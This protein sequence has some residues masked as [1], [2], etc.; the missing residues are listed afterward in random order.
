MS[1]MQ[2]EVKVIYFIFQDNFDYT[3]R[4]LWAYFLVQNCDAS[5]FLFHYF[6]FT[7]YFLHDTINMKLDR[8]VFS[9]L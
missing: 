2:K 9:A 4:T 1:G 5:Y 6:V 7:S 8:S 3:Q